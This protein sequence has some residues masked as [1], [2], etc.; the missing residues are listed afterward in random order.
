M[1]GSPV[2]LGRRT[3]FAVLRIPA[4]ITVGAGLVMDLPD[5]Y[6]SIELKTVR[7]E[8]NGRDIGVPASFGLP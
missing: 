4:L 6:R 7:R 8:E 5:L 1:V 3:D 2:Q